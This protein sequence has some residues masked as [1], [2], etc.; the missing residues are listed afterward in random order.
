MREWERAEEAAAAEMVCSPSTSDD[1]SSASSRTEDRWVGMAYHG[2]PARR[3]TRQIEAY[4]EES[5]RW[6]GAYKGVVR[7][8]QRQ[9]AAVETC[10]DSATW[11][12]SQ[13]SRESQSGERV[14]RKESSAF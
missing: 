1:E 8:L 14:R 13:V 10:T 12:F 6:S 4:V 9:S 7:A 2:K 3:A 5:G 11:L